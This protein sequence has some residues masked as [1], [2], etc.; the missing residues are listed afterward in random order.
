MPPSPSV[1]VCRQCSAQI[2]T[3]AYKIQCIVCKYWF[4]RDCVNLSIEDIQHYLR[5]KSLEHGKKWCCPTCQITNKTKISEMNKSTIEACISQD[6]IMQENTY[7]KRLV[8]ELEENNQLL[9]QN[10]ILLEEKVSD[11]EKRLS[12][13]NKTENIKKLSPIFNA[14]NSDESQESTL[15]QQII[16]PETTNSRK[17]SYSQAAQKGAHSSNTNNRDSPLNRPT[18]NKQNKPK[19]RYLNI[20]SAI[21]N[22]SDDSSNFFVGQS[23]KK[24]KKVWLFLSRIKDHVSE[25]MIKE[26]IKRKSDLN[27]EDVTV[28]HIPTNYDVKRKDCKCFQVGVKFELKDIVYQSDYWPARVAFTRF[29]FNL[30]H[31]E[32][33]SDFLEEKNIQ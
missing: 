19:R 4:H 8:K 23:E 32:A 7:L 29:K 2:K 11:L 25:D 14:N 13:K 26:Y 21:N 10:K 30:Q 12:S 5:E 6:S 24:N 1:Y 17:T 27:D 20:G 28:K 9:K 22:D 18:P 15:V 33:E 16:E 3:N 31:R